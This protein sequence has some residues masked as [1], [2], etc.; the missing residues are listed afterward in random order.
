LSKLAEKIRRATRLHAAPLGF[1][2]ARAASEPTMVLAAVA[3][4]PAQ[5]PDLARR[6]ADAIIIDLR[7][8]GAATKPAPAG[9]AAVGALIAAK[10]EGESTACKQAGY[11]FVVFDPDSAAATALLDDAIGYVLQLPK[12]LSDADARALEGL[13][14]DAIDVGQIEGSLT[15]RRQLDLRRLFALTRKPL[16]ARVRADASAAELQAL[17]DTNV[18]VIVADSPEAVERL[19]KRIDALPPRRRRREGED[20]PAPLVPLTAAVGADEE[21]GEEDGE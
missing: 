1:G 13:A 8:S 19:R 9:E 11:D 12:D 10:A 17:R 7:K 21:E 2:A 4:D 5:A 3:G 15:V 6:G 14:L 20:R 18:V 16:M